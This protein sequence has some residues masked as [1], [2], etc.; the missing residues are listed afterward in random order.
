[1]IVL[2]QSKV[3][4]FFSFHLFNYKFEKRI[5][6]GVPLEAVQ[7]SEN[8]AVLVTA[9]GGHLGYLKAKKHWFWDNDGFIEELAMQF[10]AGIFE[11]E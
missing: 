9:H 2:R 7:K 6:L 1:M 10:A 8:V 4:K 3:S 5:F 11:E